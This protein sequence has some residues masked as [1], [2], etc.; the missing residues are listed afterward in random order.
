MSD[1]KDRIERLERM[2]GTADKLEPKIWVVVEGEPLPEGIGPQDT[3]LRV[4]TDKAKALTERIIA[5]EGT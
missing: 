2:A 3:I 4:V 5:G 1:L